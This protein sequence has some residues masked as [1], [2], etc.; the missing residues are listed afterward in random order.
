MVRDRRWFV[1]GRT[2]LCCRVN[3]HRVRTQNEPTMV[4]ER[5]EKITTDFNQFNEQFDQYL[6]QVPQDTSIQLYR[7]TIVVDNI[8]L[9]D[10]HRFDT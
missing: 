3:S 1:H 2:L 6:N 7:Y 5:P 8:N 9:V 10:E 4:F